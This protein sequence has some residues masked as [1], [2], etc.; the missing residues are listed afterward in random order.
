MPDVAGESPWCATL[1]DVF[2]M[3]R[4]PLWTRPISSSWSAAATCARARR[5]R[6]MAPVL[7]A[8]NPNLG[9]V[10]RGPSP[11]GLRAAEIADITGLPLLASVRAQPQ[12]AEQLERGG[13]RLGRRSALAAAAQPGAG[14]AGACP[15]GTERQGGVS[16]SLIERVRERLAAESASLGSPLRPSVVAAAIRAESGGMLGD[17]EVLANLRVLQTELTG[18]G[19]LEPLLCADGTTDVLV[20]APDAVWVDDGKGLRRSHIRLHRRGRGAPIGAAVGAGR[21]SAARRRAA[22]GR[23]P[24]DAA[25]APEGS[26]CDC[27]R[28]CRRWRPRAPACRCGSCGRP[29]RTWRP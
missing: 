12:L 10:V 22:V 4:R 28:C 17:T 18:A 2:P 7:A 6:A 15:L 24:A 14:G 11:G 29:P 1:P 20:T 19:I 13:L 25:S 23:R 5:P 9:L 3:R 16:G 27:T 26:R 8:I 21:R